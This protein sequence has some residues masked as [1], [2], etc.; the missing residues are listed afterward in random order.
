MS[1]K[2]YTKQEIYDLLQDFLRAT[3][4]TNRFIL[5]RNHKTLMAIQAVLLKLIP[6]PDDYVFTVE[7]TR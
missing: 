6:L 4:K 3:A 1:E 2:Q 7:V 5:W